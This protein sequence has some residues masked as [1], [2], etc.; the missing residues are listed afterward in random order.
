MRFQEPLLP[1]LAAVLL[2]LASPAVAQTTPAP[3]AAAAAPAM[4]GHTPP[5]KSLIAV[6]DCNPK[7]NF[8]EYGGGYVGYAPGPWRGGYW[9]DAYGANFY[10]PPVSTTSPQLAIHYKNIAQKMMTAIEFGL[11]ANGVLVDEVRDVGTFSPHAEIKHRFAI[12]PNVFPI[13]TGL[14][15]C[16]PLRITFADGT[17]WRNPTLPPKNEHIYTNP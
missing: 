10:Q 13:R 1:I 4:A 17:K 12:S 15:Q 6:S 14:P 5:A 16:V 7:L 11:I 3:P 2:P 9:G 8:Q